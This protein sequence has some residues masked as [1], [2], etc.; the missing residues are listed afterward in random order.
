V[1]TTTT[2]ARA[3]TSLA[4]AP[5]GAGGA[6]GCGEYAAA[7]GVGGGS[8][9]RAAVQ[10]SYHCQVDAPDDV[11]GYECEAAAIESPHAG[12]VDDRGADVAAGEHFVREHT[13]GRPVPLKGG[14]CCASEPVNGD[15]CPRRTTG[16]GTSDCHNYGF[17]DVAGC[18]A[19][20]GLGRSAPPPIY[21]TPDSI[22]YSG[23]LFLKRQCVRTLD[24][25]VEQ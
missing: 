18:A 11:R 23:R 9:D 13:R 14:E 20:L 2:E 22:A 5:A 16:A 8:C 17:A 10:A 4:G 1:D 6:W 3:A 7:L 12:L 24:V 21:A 15:P 25:I 19:R